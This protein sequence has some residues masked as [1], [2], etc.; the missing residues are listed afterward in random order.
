MR[1][2]RILARLCGAALLLLALGGVAAPLRAQERD[3]AAEKAA[4]KQELL[5]RWKALSPAEREKLRQVHAAWLE[6]TTPEQRKKLRKAL[7]QRR[8]A[9]G[10]EAEAVRA[11]AKQKLDQ[12]S[13]QKKREYRE[14][15]QRLI[16]KLPPE[17]RARLAQLPPKERRQI[18]QRLINE[19]RLKVLER[20]LSGLPD[21]QRERVRAA[22]NG[23]EGNPRFVAIRRQLQSDVR[24]QARGVLADRGLTP[25]ERAR[26]LKELVRVL[27][28]DMRQQLREK[29]LAEAKK[30]DQAERE[31]RQRQEAERKAREARERQLPGRRRPR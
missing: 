7:E 12:V 30:R 25:A 13:D 20:H 21:E 1:A 19:H 28:G 11:E 26:R 8:E 4:R 29:L 23:L 14:L 9:R 24:G 17:E 10:P 16:K 2:E 6:D 3:P 31:R 5:A 15:V 18:V 22:A 27:P